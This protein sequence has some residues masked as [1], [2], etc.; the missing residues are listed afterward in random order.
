M[1]LTLE[2]EYSSLLSDLRQ[3][4]GENYSQRQWIPTQSTETYQFFISQNQKAKP[5]A[6]TVKQVIKPKIIQRQAE[7]APPQKVQKTQVSKAPTKEAPSKAT[8]LSRSVQAPIEVNRFTDVRGMLHQHFPHIQWLEEVPSDSKAISVKE[9]WR[10][11]LEKAHLIMI[12]DV[13]CDPDEKHFLHTVVSG[14]SARLAPAA[15]F[16]ASEDC[17]WE[18]IASSQALQLILSPKQCIEKHSF[19][20]N[21]CKHQVIPVDDV[22][23]MMSSVDEKRAL[24]DSVRSALGSQ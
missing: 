15:L 8:T 18:T 2:E 21:A 1:T 4:F 13:D 20:A 23:K 7:L 22:K 17:Q 3:Y 24:W 19:L 5:V 9:S 11:K 14:I 10:N 16:I 12:V 6:P